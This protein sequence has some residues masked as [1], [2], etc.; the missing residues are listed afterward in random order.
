VGFFLRI[1]TFLTVHGWSFSG[2]V[3]NLQKIIMITLEKVLSFA[4]YRYIVVSDY[5]LNL[6]LRYRITK[7]DKLKLNYNGVVISDNIKENFSSGDLHLI[8]VARFDKQKD[9]RML[10]DV[11]SKFKNITLS[12]V[13]DGPTRSSL[14]SMVKSGS[15][16]CK[17]NFLGFRKDI[18]SLLLKSDVFVLM[19]NWEGFPISTLEA[20]SVGLPVIVS[21]VGGAAECVTDGVNG[22]TI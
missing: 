6:A 22:F 10:M 11:C 8:M 4:I 3:S 16:N 20:M 7:R 2:G 14:E 18:N 1:P 15:F 12:L 17:V 21:N 13:G 5:D 19:S 9:Q